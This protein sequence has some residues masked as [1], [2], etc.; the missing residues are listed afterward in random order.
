MLTRFLPARRYASAELAVIVCPSV[1]LSVCLSVTRRYCT[2]TAKRRIAETTP[3]DGLQGLQ[4][5]VG[6]PRS[7]WN[8]RSNWPTPFR[9]HRFRP[10]SV[11]SASTVRAGKKVQLTSIASRPRALQRAIDEQCTLPLSPPNGGTKRDFAVSASKIQL[12]SKAVCYKGS[13]CED[14]QRQGCSH[15]I[16]QFNCP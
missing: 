15:T 7:P 11:H 13:L 1:C 3:R 2:K 5:L 10:I 12:L 8:L 4:T 6:N 14:V 16:P 9:T